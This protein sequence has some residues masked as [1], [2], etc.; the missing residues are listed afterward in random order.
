MEVNVY[1]TK[2]GWTNKNKSTERWITERN[3]IYI[4]SLINMGNVHST[5][6]Q[7]N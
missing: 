2:D 4:I 6:K 7:I 1:N 5:N 3:S